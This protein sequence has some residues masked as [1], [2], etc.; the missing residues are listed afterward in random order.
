M[1]QLYFLHD[2]TRKAHHLC[3]DPDRHLVRFYILINHT[4]P[5]GILYCLYLFCLILSLNIILLFEKIVDNELSQYNMKSLFGIV[6]FIEKPKDYQPDL[7]HLNN[8]Y[9]YHNYLI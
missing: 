5:L 9:K 7:L 1:R 4:R 8:Q 2:I 3:L 6:L